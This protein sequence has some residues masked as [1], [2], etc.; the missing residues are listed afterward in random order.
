MMLELAIDPLSDAISHRNTCA[1]CAV[2]GQINFDVCKVTL[3]QKRRERENR[4]VSIVVV[5]PRT[6][7][8]IQ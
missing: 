7:Q 8:G 5:Y 4:G 1:G 6:G 3:R 2:E